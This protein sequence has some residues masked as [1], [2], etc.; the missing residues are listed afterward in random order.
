MRV[1]LQLTWSDYLGPKIAVTSTVNGI[2]YVS[3]WRQR[4]LFGRK[5]C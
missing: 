4:V 5:K 1:V 2:C 3:N